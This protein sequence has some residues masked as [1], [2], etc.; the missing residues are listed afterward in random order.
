[1]GT[2]TLVLEIANGS[3]RDVTFTWNSK[4]NGHRDVTFCYNL[5]RY[6]RW[7]E[8]L[9]RWLVERTWHPRQEPIWGVT[10]FLPYSLTRAVHGRTFPKV[11]YLLPYSEFLK[12]YRM[13]RNFVAKILNLFVYHILIFLPNKAYDMSKN[14]EFN[15]KMC[16]CSISF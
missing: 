2:G 1:M 10:I 8:K 15:N 13:L 14:L 7:V 5:V 11:P 16:Y 6:S 3:I 9:D 12:Q 4:A